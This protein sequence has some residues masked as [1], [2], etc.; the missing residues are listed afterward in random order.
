[1]TNK[2][3]KKTVAWAGMACAI[4]IWS[5]AVPLTG[6]ERTAQ[7]IPSGAKILIKVYPDFVKG[8]QNGYL[9]LADV[10]F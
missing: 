7:S 6:L 3:I 8:Y 5:A 9:L 10:C 1:M 2:A 4:V